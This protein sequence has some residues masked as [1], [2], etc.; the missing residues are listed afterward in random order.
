MKLRDDIGSFQQGMDAKYA[1]PTGKWVV[2]YHQVADRHH[3]NWKMPGC[4]TVYGSAG[5]DLHSRSLALPGST[6]CGA[7]MRC[8]GGTSKLNIY[9]RRLDPVLCG[10]RGVVWIELFWIKQ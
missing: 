5:W 9:R 4:S 8:G 7:S 1:A 3:P 6:A 10:E 2:A